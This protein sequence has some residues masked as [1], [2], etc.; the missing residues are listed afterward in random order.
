MSTKFA[1]KG[2]HRARGALLATLAAL[3]TP[4]GAAAHAG[5][6]QGDHGWL[7]GAVQPLLAPDHFLAG[8]FVLG[9]GALGITIVGRS[10]AARTSRERR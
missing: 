1:W 2:S 3:G 5:H 4:A 7:L 6:G 9:V 8:V 10:R